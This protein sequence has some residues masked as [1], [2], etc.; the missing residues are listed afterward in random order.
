MIQYLRPLQIAWINDPS[1]LEARYMLIMETDEP[2]LLTNRKTTIYRV[3]GVLRPDGS[4]IEQLEDLQYSIT[5]MIRLAKR[6]HAM[7]LEKKKW[8]AHRVTAL[9]KLT[10]D[11]LRALG[12]DERGDT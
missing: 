5:R 1:S 4:P 2:D 7:E 6:K 3:D 9:A 12:I 10:P 11:E 8:N